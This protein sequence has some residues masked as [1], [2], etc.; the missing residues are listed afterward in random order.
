VLLVHTGADLYGASRSLIRLTARLARHGHAVTVVLP[1]EGPL[2]GE[3]EAGG[4]EVLIHK[5]L[6][7]VTRS[8][9]GK[10]TGLISILLRV[11]LSVLRIAR[12]VRRTR[13]HIVHTN[14]ALAFSPGLAA[15][16]C[17]ARH[18]WHVRE[19]FVEFP[20]LWR[21]YQRFMGA[22]ADRIVCVSQ[23]VADQF[24]AD[25]RAEKVVVIHNGIPQE[26]FAAA[27]RDQV[28]EFRQRF[29]LTE[30]PAVGV[31]GRIKVGRKGQEV[32]LQAASQ[33]R[34]RFPEA[35]FLLIGSPFPGN[36]AHLKEVLR[37]T[38]ELGLEDCVVYTGDVGDP[39]IA[40]ASLDVLVLPSGLP[41]PFAGVVIEAMAMGKPVIGTRHGGTCEQIEDGVTGLLVRPNDPQELAVA[42]ERLL[43]DAGLR[44]RMGEAGRARF[45]SLFEFERFYQAM[46][47]LYVSL[48]SPSARRASA[49]R[50]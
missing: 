19:F 17:G 27:P 26:E 3:L 4:V 49:T 12:L 25:L 37:L 39:R 35:R 47:E 16:F 30:G 44:R 40:H 46:L 38:R 15:R 21:W 33:L 14:T 28:E 50:R 9:Y 18:V 10:L 29:R 36:E 7:V 31:I 11:P 23:A 20:G 6:P 43:S 8:R 24:S 41:E 32:F 22:F 13:A 1:Y 48:L 5:D 2:R 34:H 42:L 45:L